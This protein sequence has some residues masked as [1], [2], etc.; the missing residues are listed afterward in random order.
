VLR[1]VAALVLATAAVGAAITWLTLFGS[2]SEL[3]FAAVMEKV[4]QTQSVTFK[5]TTVADPGGAAETDRMMILADGLSRMERPNGYYTVMDVKSGKALCVWPG[6]K[7]AKLML[8]IN[9]PPGLNPYDM[10]RNVINDKSTRLPDEVFDGRKVHVFQAEFDVGQQIRKQSRVQCPPMKVWVD[11]KTK[12]PVRMKPIVPDE[13]EGS[14][15]AI[16]DIVFDQPLEPALFSLDPPAGYAFTTEGISDL[17]APPEKPDL[18]APEVIPGVGLG[19]VKFDMSKEV[20]VKI[21]GKPEVEETGYIGY[22][23]R[24][25]GVY[26][27]LR[28]GVVAGFACFSQ[29][30]SAF[31]V[32]DFGGKTREG[33]GIGSS[34]KDLEKAFDKPDEVKGN[35]SGT[36]FVRYNR[37]GLWFSLF[38]DKVVDFKV[39]RPQTEGAKGDSAK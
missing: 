4:A 17:P 9:V 28:S 29:E 26:I 15:P 24:G 19:A 2:G 38:G 20:V 5:Q 39:M 30:A 11:P 25:Y 33:I 16:F 7:K 31:K 12:L 35:A 6:E 21:I 22:P 34:L 37:L 8:G 14:A 32:R 1:R 18:L 27:G 10:L 36:R 3:S 13:K 23:S